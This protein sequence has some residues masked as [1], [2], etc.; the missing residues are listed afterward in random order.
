MDITK[1]TLLIIKYFLYILI[2]ISFSSPHYLYSENKKGSNKK[3]EKILSAIDKRKQIKK[4]KLT[5][6]EARVIQSIVSSELHK[7][8]GII[9]GYKV[10]L[11]NKDIQ[12]KFDADKPVIGV[13]PKLMLFGRG[14]K[15]PAAFGARPMFEADLLVEVGD[16]KINDATTAMEVLA[17]L[18]K[19]STF[20][21]LP[22]MIYKKNQKLNAND[23]IAINAGAKYGYVGQGFQVEATEEWFNR[24]RDFK[25][26]VFDIDAKLIDQGKGSDLMGHPLNVVLWLIGELKAE[27]IR[28]RKGEVLSLGSI[29]KMHPVKRDEGFRAIYT[30]LSDKPTD[31]FLK[32]Y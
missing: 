2:I 16:E 1:K 19:V 29:G 28:L 6:D 22:D 12:K 23:I 21:E 3:A 13:I 10:A 17:S 26:E 18:S 20:V 30:G 5:T 9:V 11:T 7:T 4:L 24:L 15:M 31:I 27:G 25:V 32:F 8:M 14:S